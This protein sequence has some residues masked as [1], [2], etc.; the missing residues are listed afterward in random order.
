MDRIIRIHEGVRDLDRKSLNCQK[1]KYPYVHEQMHT[2]ILEDLT[3]NK[4]SHNASSLSTPFIFFFEILFH[5][6]ADHDA[7]DIGI[8]YLNI[9]V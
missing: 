1:Q 9:T 4:S 2:S 7:L 6:D 8:E 3:S 5:G